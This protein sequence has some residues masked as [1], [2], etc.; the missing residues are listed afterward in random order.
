M[1]HLRCFVMYVLT[2]RASSLLIGLCKAAGLAELRELAHND[3]ARVDPDENA[4]EYEAIDEEVRN[5]AAV[6]RDVTERGCCHYFCPVAEEREEVNRDK[7]SPKLS[8][9][10]LL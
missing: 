2:G 1:G 5:G 6:P 3:G 8:L 4:E 7:R 10:E 9:H